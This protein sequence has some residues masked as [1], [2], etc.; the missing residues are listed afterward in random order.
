MSYHQISTSI[1]DFVDISVSWILMIWVSHQQQTHLFGLSQSFS[2]VGARSVTS[3]CCSSAWS[4]S[5]VLRS[6]S[7]FLML[8]LGLL[9]ARSLE[10]PPIQ[11]LPHAVARPG[12]HKEA[13]G[14]TFSLWH[15]AIFRLVSSTCVGH[16]PLPVGKYILSLDPCSWRGFLSI[17][18]SSS[19]PYLLLNHIY[20][21]I[22]FS[23]P[24]QDRV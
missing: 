22:L 20:P 16:T 4:A 1:R 6:Y 3:S 17:R 8:W 14:G 9:S 18:L 19:C 12:Q 10:Y 23:S 21:T 15:C 2:Y 7:S 24:P 13:W 11:L 5:V